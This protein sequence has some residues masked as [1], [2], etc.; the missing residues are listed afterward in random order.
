MAIRLIFSPA[1]EPLAE[2]LAEDLRAQQQV[3]I[4]TPRRVIVPNML[5]R[6]WLESSLSE[7]LGI[8]ANIQ[9]PLL[10]SGLSDLLV[11][12]SG[13]KPQPGLSA[14][15]VALAVRVLLSSASAGSDP[16]LHDVRD[17]LRGPPEHIARRAHQLSQ[18]FGRLFREYEYHRT[19]WI[20]G[21]EAGE[22]VRDFRDSADGQPVAQAALVAALFGSN[23]L[24]R[25]ALPEQQTLRQRARA[26]LS[27]LELAQPVPVQLALFGITTL[28]PFH[29]DLLLRLGQFCELRLYQLN[30]CSEFWEDVSTPREDIWRRT[31]GWH[32]QQADDAVW[33]QAEEADNELL[34]AFG[35][36]GRE[37]IRLLSDLEERALD[38]V[39]CETDLLDWNPSGSDTLLHSVQQQIIRRQPATGDLHP[40]GTID[41]AACPGVQREVECT[42]Q[43]ILQL[44]DED[45]SLQLPEIGIIVPHITRYWPAI[46]WV[47]G[48]TRAQLPFAILDLP[49]E[50]ASSYAQGLRDVLQLAA[51]KLTRQEFFR[52]A[53]NPCFLLRHGLSRSDVDQWLR[54]AD[55]L[56]VF[57]GMGATGTERF[58]WGQALRRIRLGQVYETDCDSLGIWELDEQLA[59]LESPPY[60]DLATN[61]AERVGTLGT[62]VADLWAAVEAIQAVR[63]ASGEHWCALLDS[64]VG[65]ALAPTDSYADQRT[66]AAFSTLQAGL[67]THDTLAACC[68]GADGDLRLADI[69]A[70]LDSALAALT[71][72]RGRPLA[73]GLTI[74]SLNAMHGLPFRV[75]FMLGLE[76]GTFPGRTSPRNLDLRQTHPRLSDVSQQEQQLHW[77]LETLLCARDKLALSYVCRDLQ[78]DQEHF[79]GSALH[80]LLAYLETATGANFPVQQLPLHAADPRYL[81][82]HG[83]ATHWWA[84]KEPAAMLRLVNRAL[85]QGCLAQNDAVAAREAIREAPPSLPAVGARSEQ[86]FELTLDDLY[87][88]LYN[89][90]GATLRRTL[91]IYDL[92]QNDE[93]LTR[94][95]EEPF[96]TPKRQRDQLIVDALHH[97]TDVAAAGNEPDDTWL[98][99]QYHQLQVASAAPDGAFGQV[100]QRAVLAHYH[101]RLRGGKRQAGLRRVLQARFGSEYYP[102]L[103]LGPFEGVSPARESLQLGD[104]T[105]DGALQHVWRDPTSGHCEHLALTSR[106]IFYAETDKPTKEALRPFL[107]FLMLKAQDRL[108]PE[109]ERFLGDAP[110]DVHLFHGF[111]LS[112][113]RWTLDMDEAADY[114]ERVVGAVSMPS[115]HV[116]PLSVILDP[117]LP[118]PWQGPPA[119]ESARVAYVQQLTDAIV[120]ASEQPWRDAAPTLQR[121]LPVSV[122]S[123]AYLR[124][125]ARF[126]LFLDR[127][128]RLR[129][130]P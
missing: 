3:D 2:R 30:L 37:H 103:A 81:E 66:Q 110:F 124:V 98:V 130:V 25:R 128:Q 79:P 99:D 10:E 15:D 41:I 33:L 67:R 21:W 61:D 65:S 76:E 96:L 77:F 59:R 45:R 69:A 58:S 1:L 5:T 26:A 80:T 60:A 31:R 49:G 90:I 104:F 85:H 19:E 38:H 23:G 117:N 34:K 6:R 16:R 125:R 114:L 87:W 22:P 119:P 127:H 24:L 8:A 39:P 122:P 55:A 56:H 46:D 123:D 35:K 43:A 42:H 51:G 54:W 115:Y 97:Y 4:F 118:R 91:G 17:Y 121:L 11:T 44:L 40:D 18:R 28:S 14:D 63:G 112:S 88:A 84:L 29:R 83:P 9:L 71:T 57:H 7:H 92:D 86:Q 89:P 20:E 72:Y 111:G 108:R 82:D 95:S 113:W 75:L 68:P 32:L 129:K 64:L 48:R 106:K 27:S 36:Q 109:S 93:D 50:T 73:S 52:L 53:R 100:D 120:E 105:I 107:F 126:R 62:I 102:R 47:F 74:G 78:K 94:L 70:R 116:L 13:G 12:L 101:E